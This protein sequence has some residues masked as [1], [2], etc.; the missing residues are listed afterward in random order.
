MN[1]RGWL[2]R[3]LIHGESVQTEA[4]VFE[5]SDEPAI[6]SLLEAAYHRHAAN[7]AG[8]ALSLQFD[9]ALNAARILADACWACASSSEF[10]PSPVWQGEPKTAADHL[11]ADLL[12]RLLPGVWKRARARDLESPLCADLEELLRG[13]PLSGVMADLEGEPAHPPQFHGDTGLQ[14]L[15]AERLLANPRF[16][17]LP[18]EGRGREW[19]ERIFEEAGKPIPKELPRE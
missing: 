16:G 17:W 14:M 6:R 11:S 4:P 13:W 18:P 15:Y 12:F 9:T 7:V 5:R 8:P 1:F 3:V 10:I 19:V 2:E